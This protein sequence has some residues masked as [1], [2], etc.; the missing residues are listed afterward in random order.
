MSTLRD[1]PTWLNGEFLSPGTPAISAED[2]GFLLGLAVFDTLLCRSGR[3]IF[4]KDHIRRL[5][6][7]AAA[8]GIELPSTLDPEQGIAEVVE[9]IG[10]ELAALRLT[11]TPGAPGR[12]VS[13]VITTRPFEAPPERGVRVTLA[14]ETKASGRGLGNVKTTGR[15]RNVLA[16]AQAESQGAYEALQQTQDGDVSEGTV[17]NLFLVSGDELRTPGLD[18]GCLPGIVRGKVLEMARSLGMQP[19]E[20]SVSLDDLQ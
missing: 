18:R 15:A 19:V 2:P 10:E 7:S 6:Q 5:H 20:G 9:R 8:L 4:V 1:W 14:K 3:A 13:L 17:S 12:G 16:R 11:V